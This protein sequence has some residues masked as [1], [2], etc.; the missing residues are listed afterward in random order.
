M[1]LHQILETYQSTIILYYYTSRY[2]ALYC[3]NFTDSELIE[4]CLMSIEDFKAVTHA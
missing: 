1:E 2:E 4:F 3:E